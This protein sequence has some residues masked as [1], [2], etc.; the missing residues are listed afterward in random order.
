MDTGVIREKKTDSKKEQKVVAITIC[1]HRLIKLTIWV[2]NPAL[3]TKRRRVNKKKPEIINKYFIK[4]PMKLLHIRENGN[5]NQI[6]KAYKEIPK[7]S[8]TG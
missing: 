8:N 6:G 5:R 4:I 2:G 7:S 1:T 3:N